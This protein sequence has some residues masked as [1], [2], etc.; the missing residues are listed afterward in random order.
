MNYKEIFKKTKP[1][2][3]SQSFTTNF[4]IFLGCFIFIFL[5]TKVSDHLENMSEKQLVKRELRGMTVGDIT[6]K[7]SDGDGV[8][9]WEEYLWNTDPEKEDSDEDG[10]SDLIFVQ[11]KRDE[12]QER[13]GFSTTETN[14]T[15]EAIAREYFSTIIALEQSGGLTTE[16]MTNLA[17]S[18]AENIGLVELPPVFSEGDIKTTVPSFETRLAYKNSVSTALVGNGGNTIGTEF[19]YVDQLVRDEYSRSV[20]ISS[21]QGIANSY[22][23]FASSVSS[24][25]VPSDIKDTHVSFINALYNTG[26]SL[27]TLALFWDDP[28]AGIQGLLQYKYYSS[29][30]EENLST[31]DS[32]FSKNGIL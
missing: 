26:L 3:P 13:T 24:L 30:V 27:E 23:M 14:T 9:D 32:Y 22:K 17:T 6:K 8:S 25:D 31:F 15:T 19:S 20:S 12:L 28:I 7:D 5:L 4:G 2:L 1:Y 10:V 11:E 18:F 16:A 29:I 21:I